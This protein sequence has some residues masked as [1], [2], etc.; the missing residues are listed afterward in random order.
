MKIFPT[1]SFEMKTDYPVK[2]LIRILKDSIDN[3]ESILG[4]S[5]KKIF[6]GNI[7]EKGFKLRR[8]PFLTFSNIY[9]FGTFI[10]S[11]DKSNIKV[12]V[13]YFYPVYAFL[14]LWLLISIIMAREIYPIIMNESLAFLGDIIL[15]LIPIS[16]FGIGYLFFM[17]PFLIDLKKTKALLK[18]VLNNNVTSEHVA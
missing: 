18:K 10:D 8:V 16:F 2:H 9:Y 4:S 11:N 6:T 3:K 15:I 7:D 17:L 1:D 5:G 12:R 14:I 13:R